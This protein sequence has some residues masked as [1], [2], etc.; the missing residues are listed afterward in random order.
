MLL[1]G[2]TGINVG[3]G[4]N[5]PKTGLPEQKKLRSNGTLVLMGLQ[6]G[7]PQ[8][9]REQRTN[10]ATDRGGGKMAGGARPGRAYLTQK[11]VEGQEPENRMAGAENGEG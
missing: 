8:L 11:A 7:H 9:R 5:E 3:M 4:G 10:P 6:V 1:T 2:E